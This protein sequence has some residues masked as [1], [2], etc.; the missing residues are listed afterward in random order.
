VRRI[1]TIFAIESEINGLLTNDRLAVRTT[2][3]APLM[4]EL[5][6]N[7]ELPSHPDRL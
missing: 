3:I 2:R 6:T 1:D 7:A 4:A 5:E